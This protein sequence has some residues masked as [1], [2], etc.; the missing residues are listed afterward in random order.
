MKK[1]LIAIVLLASTTIFAQTSKPV[2]VQ[3]K[4]ITKA[5]NQCSRKAKVGD[6]CTQHAKMVA[7]GKKV[8]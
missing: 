5:G 3:C 1:L 4:A 7:E 2:T 6:Y 8:N